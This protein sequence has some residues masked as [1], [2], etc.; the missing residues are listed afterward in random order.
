MSAAELAGERYEPL[1]PFLAPR[2]QSDSGS[3][4]GRG[5]GGGGGGAFRVVLD[6]YVG[7]GTP[8]PPPSY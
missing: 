8:S 1:F 6:D 7:S 4:S 3:D 2:F 5:G